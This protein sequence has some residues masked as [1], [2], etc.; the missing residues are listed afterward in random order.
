MSEA[1]MRSAIERRL[2]SQ[3][4]AYDRGPVHLFF[5]N[6]KGNKPEGE[7]Y[8]EFTILEGNSRRANLGGKRTVRQVGV[9]QIDVMYPKDTGMGGVSRL[10]TFCGKLFDEWAHTLPDNATV[11]FKTPK[12]VSMGIAGEF[13]RV[14]VSIAYW[15]DEKSG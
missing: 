2:Q 9:L 14:A 13:Q 8:V 4:A 15:R 3:L 10:A 6:S 11:H 1:T 5:E 7:P 12:Q